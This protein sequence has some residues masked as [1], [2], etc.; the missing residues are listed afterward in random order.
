MLKYSP[1][2]YLKFRLPDGTIRDGFFR[3]PQRLGDIIAGFGIKGETELDQDKSI[4][5]LGLKND[6]MVIV[7]K[8]KGGL[9]RKML[10]R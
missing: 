10:K 2:V 4:G 1:K 6:D 3:Q 5:E 9:L 7:S 8:V